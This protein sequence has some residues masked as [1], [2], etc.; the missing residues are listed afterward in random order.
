MNTGSGVAPAASSLPP[1]SAGWGDR[2]QA[3]LNLP[4]TIF[5]TVRG[6][7]E[8]TEGQTG[9]ECSDTPVVE[10]LSLCFSGE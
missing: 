10:G 4:L 5:K 8:I 1:P 2:P 3:A 6:I 7:Q 9:H